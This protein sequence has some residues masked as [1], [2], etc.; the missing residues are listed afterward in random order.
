MNFNDDSLL[1]KHINIM[2]KV[3]NE[4]SMKKQI[5]YNVHKNAFYESVFQ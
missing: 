5:K 1:L 3:K 4:L 2:S